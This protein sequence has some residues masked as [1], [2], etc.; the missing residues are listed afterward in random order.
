MSLLVGQA[1]LQDALKQ[2]RIVWR[3]TKTKWDDEA[4]RAFEREH[5]EPLEPKIRATMI[6]LAR[7]DEVARAAE[8]ECE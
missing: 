8:R 5:L 3:E 2:L 7:L 1:K 6:A 4:S